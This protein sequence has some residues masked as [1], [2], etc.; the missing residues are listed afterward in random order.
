[1][2]SCRKCGQPAQVPVSIRTGDGP[3]YTFDCFDCAIEMVAPRC[4][5]C[6][7]AYLGRPVTSGEHRFCSTACSQRRQVRE[8]WSPAQ[9]EGSIDGTGTT[10]PRIGVALGD[11]SEQL[12]DG[13]F[14]DAHVGDVLVV[15]CRSI[16]RPPRRATIIEVRG[17]EGMPPYVVRWHE[18]DHESLCFPGADATLERH[19]TRAATPA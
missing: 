14:A 3:S 13:G 6:R 18:D 10:P 2:R 19:A 9:G 8:A 4:P 11:D 15:H 12:F 5:E 1:M 17:S 7:R 16:D